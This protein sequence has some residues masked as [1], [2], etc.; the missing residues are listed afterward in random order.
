M[1]AI[2]FRVVGQ[3]RPC[4]FGAESFAPDTTCQVAEGLV[5]DGIECSHFG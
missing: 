5:A 1:H 3:L 2:E 4:G